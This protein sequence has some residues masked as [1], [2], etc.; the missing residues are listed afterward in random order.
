MK[1]SLL[2]F[3]FVLLMGGT[4]FAAPHVSVNVKPLISGS[5]SASVVP[6]VMVYARD[7]GTNELLSSGISGPDGADLSL[8]LDRKL[9]VSTSGTPGLPGQ[10]LYYDTLDGVGF[11]PIFVLNNDSGTVQMCRTDITSCTSYLVVSLYRESGHRD[12][13]CIDSDATS[14]PS[15]LYVR[16]TV[17]YTSSNDGVTSSGSKTDYCEDSTNLIEYYCT[18]NTANSARIACPSGSV[19]K[20]G[21][22]V[23]SSSTPSSEGPYCTD[24]DGGDY[25]YQQG[26]TTVYTDNTKSQIASVSTD[27]CDGSG[28]VIEHFCGQDNK[29]NKVDEPCPS[30]YSCSEGACVANNVSTT[31]SAQPAQGTNSCS[32]NNPK[33]DPGIQ[34]TTK[35]YTV[36]ADGTS[37][38]GVKIDFCTDST[39]AFKY[40]C[41]G[42][43]LDYSTVECSAGYSCTGGACVQNESSVVPESQPPMPPG[44]ET[45]FALNLENGWNLLSVP[46]QKGRVVSNTCSRSTAFTYDPASNQYVAMNLGSSADA[47]FG[48][49]GFWMKADAPCQIVI[50]GNT[51]VSDL[52][53]KSLTKGWNL[54]GAPDSGV[55]YSDVKGSCVSESGPWGFDTLDNKWVKATTFEAGKGYFLKVSEDCSFG[56]SDAPPALP[57]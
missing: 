4:I 9:Y 31:P 16:G 7:A 54:L 36:N 10:Y 48:G 20:E 46:F 23:V 21:A 18:N 38:T 5:A 56:S 34:G 26:T 33:S 39:H 45:S 42:D 22:C 41:K 13:S 57:S 43:V 47:S 29:D 49:I 2:V 37:S 3:A 40:T 6:G 25:I 51:A 35:F 19:C 55:V 1:N 32:T 30:G 28:N 14:S 8:P 17:D 52:S 44:A 11:E 12:I 50:N 27:Q 15:Y 53:G 24:S